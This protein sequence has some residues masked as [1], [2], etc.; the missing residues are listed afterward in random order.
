M[1]D[2]MK[3]SRKLWIILC[4]LL[5]AGGAWWKFGPGLDDEDVQNSRTVKVTRET[6]EE[7]VTAQG[8]LEPKEY[9]DVGAQ[10]SGQLKKLHVEIGDVV[11]KGDLLAELDPRV[12]ESRVEGD[13]ARLRTLEAQ[14]NQQKAQAV[15]AGQQY[16]RNKR[17]MEAKAVSQEALQESLSAL[18]VADAGVASS[19]AQIEEINSTLEGDMAN[20]SYT[21]IYAP[22]DGTVV[23][24]PTREGQTV[25]ASQTAPVIVQLADL[26]VMTVKAQVAEAD[27]MRLKE[28]MEV[29][30][31]TLGNLE[32]RWKGKL[33]QIQPSPEVI[34]DVVLYDAL[35]DVDNKDRQLM[36]GMS[37]QVFFELQRAD[38]VLTIPVEALGK[39]VK[40]QD[41]EQLGQAYMAHVKDGKK[42]TDKLVHIGLMSRT[43]AEVKDGLTENDELVI[44]QRPTGNKQ[45]GGK[46]AGGRSGM[47]GGPRL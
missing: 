38:N 10:V 13:K 25:N 26:D 33:W 7:T 46:A 28:G 41:S 6:I 3:K 32:R 47:R 21:K 2:R 39:R 34:N 30:F 37:V 23:L 24:Q 14:L 44:R 1:A 5:L 19:K 35:I 16:E 36:T 4:L 42:T 29:S 27:V 15:F 31:T 8:K 11:K 45:T 20:L 18:K 22:M 12:Y 40:A 9:V 43:Q 17:L